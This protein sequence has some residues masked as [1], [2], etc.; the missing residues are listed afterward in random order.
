M[1]AICLINCSAHDEPG[2]DRTGYHKKRTHTNLYPRSRQQQ[3][4]RLRN[5]KKQ[6]K[7]VDH[8][9]ARRPEGQRGRSADHLC[10][11]PRP[12]STAHDP[13]QSVRCRS[14]GE[15]LSRA[16]AC[17]RARTQS[18]VC[19]NRP[20]YASGMLPRRVGIEAEQSAGPYQQ[21]PQPLFSYSRPFPGFCW[22]VSGSV[23]QTRIGRSHS[24]CAGVGGAGVA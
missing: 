24:G 7:V 16:T 15:S 19:T 2:Q 9:R 6:N 20:V 12:T 4:S 23:G 22:P 13:R 18:H 3:S 21:K 17:R 10:A 11:Y 5:R 14:R 8:I 1:D